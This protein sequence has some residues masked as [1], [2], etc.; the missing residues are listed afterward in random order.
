MFERNCT[1]CPLLAQPST[2]GPMRIPS[3]ISGTT[4]G[5]M[6]PGI[7]RDRNAAA[8]EAAKT[9][10]SERRSDCDGV[11][12]GAAAASRMFTRRRRRRG[13]PGRSRRS[14]SRPMRGATRASASRG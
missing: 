7:I 12:I 5:R 1:Y 6:R 4:T 3:T 11:G 8:A 10:V 14:T 13:A 9:S 2:S